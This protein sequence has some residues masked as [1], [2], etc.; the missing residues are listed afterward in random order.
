MNMNFLLVIFAFVIKI[1]T[2]AGNIGSDIEYILEKRH[3]TQCPLCVDNGSHSNLLEW[4]LLNGGE[5]NPKQEVR[6]IGCEP[7]ASN[8]YGVF[9]VED[10][11][12]GEILTRIP[13]SIILSGDDGDD[14][15]DDDDDNSLDCS[16]IDRVA[17]A[18]ADVSFAPYI[19]YLRS[20]ENIRP[21]D[22]WSL[23][24]SRLMFKIIGFNLPPTKLSRLVDSTLIDFV[25]EECE[26]QIV[27]T[28]TVY[29]I[30]LMNL[31]FGNKIGLVPFADFYN[32]RKGK[33]SNVNH[34]TI[35]DDGTVTFI[36]SKSIK[37]GDQLYLDIENNGDIT[38]SELFY[39]TGFIEEY[40]QKWIIG[41]NLKFVIDSPVIES[42][43]TNFTWLS[44]QPSFHDILF[45]EG[46]LDRLQSLN[47][48][49]EN[50][51][52]EID[53]GSLC[54]FEWDRVWHYHDALLTAINGAVKASNKS[55]STS[56]EQDQIYIR[57]Y[58]LNKENIDETCGL[59]NDWYVD[60]DIVDYVSSPYQDI[61][62]FQIKERNELCFKLNGIIHTCSSFRPSMHEVYVHYP[63]SYLKSL[64]RVVF[65]GGGDSMVLHE[66]LKYSS[67][68]YVLGIELDQ[69]VTR[70]SFKHFYTQPH[71]DDQRVHWIFGDATKSLK[72]IP[73][74]YYQ[75]F[76]LVIVDVTDDVMELP[77]FGAIDLLNVAS[78]LT[79][80]DG[81]LIVNDHMI[82]SLR[83][84]FKYTMEIQFNSHPIYCQQAFVLGSQE[85]NFSKPNFQLMRESKLVN[86]FYNPLLNLKDHYAPIYRYYE[87]STLGYSK[88][89]CSAFFKT[90]VNNGGAPHS[91]VV[92]IFDIENSS[93]SNMSTEEVNSE[94]V[95]LVKRLGMTGI[96]STSHSLLDDT[97]INIFN[98]IVMDQGYVMI[99]TLR[100]FRYSAI[101]VHIWDKLELID[102]LRNAIFKLTETSKSGP[103]SQFSILVGNNFLSDNSKKE[104]G[105]LDQYNCT[106]EFSYE[107]TELT[108]D[109][110]SKILI[111][112]STILVDEEDGI[113]LIL[114]SDAN[115]GSCNYLDSLGSYKKR[116][117]VI[118]IS[119][120]NNV[121]DCPSDQTTSNGLKKVFLHEQTL[122][123]ALEM[124]VAEQTK[125]SFL[126]IDPNTS[127]QLIYSIEKI[128]VQ[129]ILKDSFFTS[130]L[131]VAM[132]R[133]ESLNNSMRN[134]L[135]RLT[136]IGEDFGTS[137]KTLID[138]TNGRIEIGVFA[139]GK[140]NTSSLLHDYFATIKLKHGQIQFTNT[141]FTSTIPKY[142][143]DVDYD[144]YRYSVKDYD[145]QPGYDQFLNQKQ[146]GTQFLLKLQLNQS[147][148]EENRDNTQRDIMDVL[149]RV[150]QDED[151]EIQ[152]Q[153]LDFSPISRMFFVVSSY[154]Q[155]IAI[156]DGFESIE[157][158]FFTQKFE[159]RFANLGF[160]YDF[161]KTQLNV[162]KIEY[163][164]SQPRGI[165]RVVTFTSPSFNET[166]NMSQ[167]IHM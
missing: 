131:V 114:C 53:T 95:A 156:W 33:W 143:V 87:N 149:T 26:I 145:I 132:A 146:L 22:L 105:M 19:N 120:T 117:A 65:L 40:P 30:N 89:E 57:S 51:I 150:Y 39:L 140:K 111:E 137:M 14:D 86:K 70:Q 164:G 28:M 159:S 73:N 49:K 6:Y 48:V 134:L 54:S 79:K 56:S 103:I 161:F 160:F 101:D 118:G 113:S 135:H 34:P 83:N 154:G 1:F 71:F 129:K 76:D 32:H 67:V 16:L 148:S 37:A 29:F 124:I 167:E 166:K 147:S 138:Y 90:G 45:L 91:G 84:I 4:I 100:K 62:F 123:G 165:N 142:P 151:I 116:T 46:E 42:Q 128:F 47:N 122:E 94:M 50:G 61:L 10:I 80:K 88:F 55:V 92:T 69:E 133:D 155:L 44:P 108:S 152:I 163:Y 107:S 109:E 60:T 110:A 78:L 2:C 127:P 158:N 41:G 74:E 72:I 81:I 112:E 35:D 119:S 36:A 24:A 38:T 141:N 21:S 130:N 153:E 43:T 58:D 66:I 115:A 157:V 97:G 162:Q 121:K 85:L 139:A 75:S 8:S 99:R 11:D 106:P 125:I 102:E 68:E 126:Y 96:T 20:L 15:D 17:D 63:T 5:L 25:E 82:D 136:T 104:N 9:A 77:V 3:V 98:I 23:S 52:M 27:S 12:E 64:R 13:K 31:M 144:T 18:I 7:M 59:Q 93:L